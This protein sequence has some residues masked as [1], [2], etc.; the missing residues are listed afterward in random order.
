M[1]TQTDPAIRS[2]VDAALSAAATENERVQKRKAGA[3]YSPDLSATPDCVTSEDPV[4]NE[5]VS[6]P[7]A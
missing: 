2:A 1:T 5:S 3:S 7:A 6:P 4:P